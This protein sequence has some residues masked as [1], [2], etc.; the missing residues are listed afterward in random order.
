MLNNIR[1]CECWL[2]CNLREQATE[3]G[4]IS[5]SLQEYP[6]GAVYVLI[7]AETVLVTISVELPAAA[8]GV[9]AVGG[10]A[11][12]GSIGVSALG[13]GAGR[14]T[15]WS[16]VS[17]SISWGSVGSGIGVSA[18]SGGVG[19]IE[20]APCRSALRNG[21]AMVHPS[22]YRLASSACAGSL[23]SSATAALFRRPNRRAAVNSSQTLI[24]S[25][26]PVRSSRRRDGLHSS[27]RPVACLC[28]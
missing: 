22:I 21:F 14:L 18:D 25:N 17:T 27:T 1:R 16:R 13:G 23:S 10:D 3:E 15:G 6:T 2:R 8:G 28:G 9:L 4:A 5:Q 7:H 11:G 24:W 20:G 12:G 19:R 26:A